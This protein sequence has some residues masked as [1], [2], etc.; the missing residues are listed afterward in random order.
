VI[1]QSL[2]EPVALFACDQA[3]TDWREWD[4]RTVRRELAE[5]LEARG[6][7][8]KVLRNGVTVGYRYLP[9]V[10]SGRVSLPTL[11]MATMVAASEVSAADEAIGL[12]DSRQRHEVAK[13]RMW[14]FEHDRRNK[15]T[16]G[17]AVSEAD[18]RYARKLVRSNGLTWGRG[19]REQQAA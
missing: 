12:M 7:A 17:P 1:R 15:M 9:P 10:S 2:Y 3:A 18:V 16:V 11:T 19:Q 14:P 8:E 5:R 6:Q 13:L 4:K